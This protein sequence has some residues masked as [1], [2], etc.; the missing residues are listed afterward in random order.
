MMD[1]LA[2]PQGGDPVVVEGWFRASPERVFE[3]WTVP[4]QVRRWFGRRPGGMLSA[5]IDLRPGGA[6]RFGMPSDGPDAHFL[7][8]AYAV[9]APAEL[10]A[11]T[12]RHVVAAPGVKPV[13]SRDSVVTVSFQA[14]GGGVRTRVV[15]A[16]LREDDARRGVGAGWDASLKFLSGDLGVE[17]RAAVPEA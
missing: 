5:E 17:L 9:V 11:F 4:E 14:L 15:H 1:F 7:E 10:L 2:T 3:A 13:S 8:G 16:G 12:W 6:W